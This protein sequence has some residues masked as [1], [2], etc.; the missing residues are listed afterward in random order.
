MLIVV[1]VTRSIGTPAPIVE[2]EAAYPAPV[3]V[4]S[5]EVKTIALPEPSVT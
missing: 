4:Q 1:A 5:A 3:S 2:V